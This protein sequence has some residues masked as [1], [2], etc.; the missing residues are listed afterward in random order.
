MLLPNHYTA[1]TRR[2]DVAGFTAIEML[3]V[4]T[5]FGVLAMIAAPSFSALI[6][7]Q[8]AGSAATELYVAMS[9]ARS[10]AIKRNA[11][12]WLCP[13]TAGAAG[14]KDGWQIRSSDCSDLGLTTLDDHALISG[15]NVSGPPSV[16]Y[17][18]SGR[19]Q[20]SSAPAF[21]IS[22]TSGS[23]SIQKY[24]CVDLSG[25]PAVRTSSCP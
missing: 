16:T 24:L 14:W 25:R 4:V 8:R 21:G 20:G 9:K 3:T 6:A 17:Q 22:T 13:K 11:S 1:R 12:V 23:S 10:E 19:V 5:I 7:G 18:R 2:R 15:A